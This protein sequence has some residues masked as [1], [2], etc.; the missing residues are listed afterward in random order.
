MM[1]DPSGMMYPDG[2]RWLFL[3]Y[4]VFFLALHLL[5]KPTPTRGK[6]RP[7]EDRMTPNA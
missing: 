7:V 5:Q 4:A 1:N 3:V 2:I 6:G